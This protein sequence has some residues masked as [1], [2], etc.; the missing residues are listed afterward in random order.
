MRKSQFVF[1]DPPPKWTGSVAVKRIPETRWY[2]EGGPI[3][4]FKHWMRELHQHLPGDLIPMP[5]VPEFVG[6]T[7]GAVKKRADAG[8]LTVFTF[9][10]EEAQRSM[11][12][13]RAYR[14]TKSRF[15]YMV[16]S[17]C[18][19]WREDV[20]ARLEKEEQERFRRE[21][22]KRQGRKRKKR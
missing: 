8:S 1:V 4:H 17:E 10:V 6:V 18:E 2:V 20:L 5:W 21:N 14:E 9:I 22:E 3:M 12:G 13:K 11:L 19:A 15:D 7:R 16:I